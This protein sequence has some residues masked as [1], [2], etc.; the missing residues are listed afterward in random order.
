MQY[1]RNIEIPANTAT[2]NLLD[3]RIKISAGTIT[4]VL[5]HIPWG[6]AN[7]VGLQIFYNTW[8]IL[9]LSRGEFLGGNDFTHRYQLHYEISEEPYELKVLSYNDDDTYEHTIPVIV[10]MSRKVVNQ[11]LKQLLELIT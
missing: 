11:K 7:L 5:I 6:C 1:K 8:Q 4:E 3:T 10:T 2:S 9:P